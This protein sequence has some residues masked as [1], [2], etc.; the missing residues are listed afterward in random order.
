[1]YY[2][3]KNISYSQKLLNPVVKY[4]KNENEFDRY[5]TPTGL[6]TDQK[7]YRNR[8]KT[9][10]INYIKKEGN[11][12]QSRKK[13]KENEGIKHLI[14]SPI[15]PELYNKLNNEEK[16]KLQQLI[17]KQ[18]F[19]DF[20]GYGFIGG[21][22][23]KN[24][25]ELDHFH[26][27]IGI[28]EKYDIKPQNIDY[29]KRSITKTLLNSE[30]KEKLGLKTSN[31]L[32][33]ETFKNKYKELYEEKQQT[34]QHISIL[35]NELLN[36]NNEIKH[37]KT[38]ID[39]I[40]FDI[41]E[42]NTKRK[43]EL[44]I[45]HKE[46]DF[47]ISDIQDTKQ[48][49]KYKN[50]SLKEINNEFKKTFESF[51]YEKDNVYNT[52]KNELQGLKN[53]LNNEYKYFKEFLKFE[54]NIYV[55]FLKQ[56][57]KNKEID[58]PTFLYL[59]GVNKYYMKQRQQ[60]K[61]EEIQQ[62]IKDKQEY[63]QKKLQELQ[64]K[65]KYKLQYLENRKDWIE[66]FKKF[67]EKKIQKLYDK[68]NEINGKYKNTIDRYLNRIDIIY[69]YLHTR[70]KRFFELLEMKRE[71]QREI[72]K[73][74]IKYYYT[75][76]Q[77]KEIKS[78]LYSNEIIEIME[79]YGITEEELKTEYE[80]FLQDKKKYPDIIFTNYLKGYGK[81]KIIKMKNTGIGQNQETYIKLN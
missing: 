50:E 22:E 43:E 5:I 9:S 39:Y 29:L 11:T 70:Q 67:D 30:F 64:N 68:L 31:E 36:I 76:Q 25:G 15:S 13:I 2:R 45:I 32:R 59:A 21:I 65:L 81:Q 79:K 35:F 58:L 63:I 57:L 52:L 55:K 61:K 72:Q 69:R 26:I 49:L 40:K 51:K 33:Q 60:Y 41:G 38:H 48:I 3:N 28:S 73:E 77:Y 24:R 42:L 44:R 47:L 80:K 1:M 23:K 27:H 75:Q 54:H 8:Q 71:K 66:F 74:K 17:V 14:I 20:T 4:M 34:Y 62:K 12:F 46:K 37:E 6:K 53:T 19:K 10:L 56:Q 18:L 78:Y 16:E 7:V